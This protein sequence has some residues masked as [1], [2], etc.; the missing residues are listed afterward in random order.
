MKIHNSN[1]YPSKKHGPLLY[2]DDASLGYKNIGGAIPNR[3]NYIEAAA[4][5]NIVTN[6]GKVYMLI[7]DMPIRESN[8]VVS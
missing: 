7:R 5:D 1:I 3:Q 2:A 6:W 8:G 4:P